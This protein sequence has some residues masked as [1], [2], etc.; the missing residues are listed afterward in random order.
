MCTCRWEPQHMIQHQAEHLILSQG[1]GLFSCMRTT[2]LP[3][4]IPNCSQGLNLQRLRVFN[5]QANIMFQNL[6]PAPR[7]HIRK[8]PR[9][10]MS[11]LLL[12]AVS[13]LRCCLRTASNQAACATSL[14][15]ALQCCVEAGNRPWSRT[16]NFV[17][18]R[19]T[20][21]IAPTQVRMQADC[22]CS[23]D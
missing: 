1:Q 14:M 12:L 7:Q 3:N 21:C 2:W 13:S 11:A 18:T 10:P 9:P 16:K 4:C 17:I 15:P 5:Y 19:S 6:F 23:T 22:A 8:S 20:G